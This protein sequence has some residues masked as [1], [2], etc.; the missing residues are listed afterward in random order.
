MYLILP[1]YYVDLFSWSWLNCDL[2]Q[3]LR[4]RLLFWYFDLS[5]TVLKPFFSVSARHCK[6]ALVPMMAVWFFSPPPSFLVKTFALKLN[7]PPKISLVQEL[8]WLTA[9][10][11]SPLEKQWSRWDNG[12]DLRLDHRILI[13]YF[14]FGKKK[15]VWIRV[16]DVCSFKPA[17]L[18]KLIPCPFVVTT[19][20][21]V[22]LQET[23]MENLQ[24]MKRVRTITCRSLMKY[25]S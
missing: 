15:G 9:W 25:Q 22:A 7:K 11:I 10:P 14:P 8:N 4:K 1:F 19:F 23:E 6:R 21:S 12:S 17:V 18:F 20:A 3:D 5:N 2:T 24:R 13:F 16:M